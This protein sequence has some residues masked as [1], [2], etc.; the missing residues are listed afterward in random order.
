MTPA[1]GSKAS[2][3]AIVVPATLVGAVLM[4]VVPVPHVL[5]DLMLAANIAA[6]VVILLVVMFS[7]D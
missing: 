1:T 6:A 3:M 5:L 7:Q 4:M 2:K